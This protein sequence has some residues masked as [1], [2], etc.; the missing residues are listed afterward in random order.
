MAGDTMKSSPKMPRS[1]S[2]SARTCSGV[3]NGR[4]CWVS[5]PPMNMSLPRY[6]DASVSA[7][8]PRAGLQGMEKLHACVNQPRDERLDGAAG[9]KRHRQAR[10]PDGVR[11]PANGGR[12]NSSK[13][14]R[15]T[16]MLICVPRSLPKKPADRYGAVCR[17]RAVLAL[18][19]KSTTRRVTAC[20]TSGCVYIFTK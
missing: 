5:T 4:S 3:P 8:M 6:L 18:T 2:T 10:L 9:V 13:Q 1:R 16:I 15:L 17:S 20:T 12:M 19:R 7:S 11:N 14:S